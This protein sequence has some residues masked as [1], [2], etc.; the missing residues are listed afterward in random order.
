LSAI[1]F[2]E[3]SLKVPQ[4]KILGRRRDHDYDD[5]N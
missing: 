4:A 2:T 5:D 3:P 1:K